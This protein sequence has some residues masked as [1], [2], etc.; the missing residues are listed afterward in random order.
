MIGVEED[1]PLPLKDEATIEA[2]ADVLLKF[3]F[4]VIARAY[5]N[6]LLEAFVSRL[7]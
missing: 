3:S 4:D 2:L 5:D 7:R 1:K 6:K